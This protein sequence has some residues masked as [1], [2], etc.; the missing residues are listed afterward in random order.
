VSEN[1]LVGAKAGG[2]HTHLVVEGVA[3][4]GCSA[5]DFDASRTAIRRPRCPADPSRRL[6]RV[7]ACGSSFTESVAC[8]ELLTGH[9]GPC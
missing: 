7:L 3:W 4:N 6:K 9:S 2:I 1:S 5:H 8:A